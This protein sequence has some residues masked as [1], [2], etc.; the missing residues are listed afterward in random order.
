MNEAQVSLFRPFLFCPDLALGLT[1]LYSPLGLLC[2][3]NKNKQTLKAGI[4][5][6]TKC[7]VI[8]AMKRWEKEEDGEH[9]T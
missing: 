7:L 6:I 5:L 3:K 1:L 2:K 9:K 4:F 8:S